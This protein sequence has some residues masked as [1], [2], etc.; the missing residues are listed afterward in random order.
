MRILKLSNPRLSF[1]LVKTL[2]LVGFSLMVKKRKI[3]SSV[4]LKKG[5]ERLLMNRL[6]SQIY[7][8]LMPRMTESW[9]SIN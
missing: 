9:D 1:N 3:L 5:H 8:D 4:S 6:D 7:S 2:V